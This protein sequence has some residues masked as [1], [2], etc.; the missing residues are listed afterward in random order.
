MLDSILAQSFQ[1]WRLYVVDDQST[2]SS[3]DIVKE[4][5]EKDSR[6]HDV[7]R[8]REPKGAQTC[9]NIGFDRTEGAEY[10]M[11]FD[12][13]DVIAPYCFEQRIN[14]MERHPELD[15]GIFPAITFQD[16]L[17]E[18]KAWCYGFPLGWNELQAMLLGTLPMVG[19]TNIYRKSSLKRKMHCWDENILSGQD[20][21][22]SI[23]S[24][25][26]GFNYDYAIKE[27][28]RADYFYRTK[29]NPNRISSKILTEAHFSSHLY[30]MQKS[31]KS[32]GKE[33]KRQYQKELEVYLYNSAKILS[34]S[35]EYYNQIFAIPWVKEHKIFMLRLWM[36][37]ICGFRLGERF[38]FRK[39]SSRGLL[40]KEEWRCLVKNSYTKWLANSSVD[41]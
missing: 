2:D 40:A 6:I 20:F 33:Q 8:H 17:W 21:D 38:V 39:I 13:D 18:K 29:P 28:A 34:K 3:L 9:R 22:F 24:I 25:L 26:L 16:E 15:F 23:Q 4:Y 5:A 7:V 41:C 31:I 14:Y 35:I 19:W 37:K 12:A 36:W 11:W 30:L 32:L 27:G 1:D 10:V